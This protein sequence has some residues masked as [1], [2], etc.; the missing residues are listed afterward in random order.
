VKEEET[1]KSTT[2][3]KGQLERNKD[4]QS[5]KMGRKTAVITRSAGRIQR[6][7]WLSS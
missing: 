4:T 1:M 5:E 7:R 2:Q 3:E 6:L